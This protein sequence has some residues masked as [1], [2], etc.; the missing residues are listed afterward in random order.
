MSAVASARYFTDLL[1]DELA[2]AHTGDQFNG[3]WTDDA[4]AP[5]NAG[6]AA[7]LAGCGQGEDGGKTDAMERSRWRKQALDWLR[8]ALNMWTK[9]IDDGKPEI[10]A[11]AAKNL[12]HWQEDSDLAGVRDKDALAKLPADEQ[13][14]WGKLWADVDAV[15]K[16]AQVK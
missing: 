12:Q 15:L 9:Q 11:A 3:K 10:R 7:A 5:Y 1:D 13:G 8:V 4:I 2:D 6:C 16:K 14:A